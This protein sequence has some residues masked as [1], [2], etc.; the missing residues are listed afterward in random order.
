MEIHVWMF[1][2]FL[3]ALLKCCQLG[4]NDQAV[5]GL[6]GDGQLMMGNDGRLQAA[7]E[8]GYNLISRGS[9][10]HISRIPPIKL[11]ASRTGTHSKMKLCLKL[12]LTFIP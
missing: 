11:I 9:M 12:Q 6:Q 5:Q 3:S 8:T 10:P 7:L 2:I 4:T 1:D